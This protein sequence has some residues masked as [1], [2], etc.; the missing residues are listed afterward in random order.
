MSAVADRCFHVF[1]GNSTC[2]FLSLCIKFLIVV[3]ASLKLRSCTNGAVVHNSACSILLT[4]Y[5]F[6]QLN[7]TLILCLLGCYSPLFETCTY[8]PYV[9]VWS[10]LKCEIWV[11]RSSKILTLHSWTSDIDTVTISAMFINFYV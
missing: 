4:P 3:P 7:C 9:P 5:T 10:N 1:R 2:S 11:V 8:Q 6:K